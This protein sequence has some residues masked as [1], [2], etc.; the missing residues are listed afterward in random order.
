MKL[1]I[2]KVLKPQGIK[3]ELKVQPLSSPEFF[4]E[5]PQVFIAGK[6]A[7]IEYV[8][9]RN[10]G[11]YLKLDLIND[12]N[13]AEEYRD[14]IIYA[15]R[16]ALPELKKN[17]Y[18]YDDLIGCDVVFEDGEGVGELVD[19]QNYGTADIFEI[20]RG[21]TAILVPFVEGVFENID[22]VNKKIVANRKR[23]L[24]VTDYED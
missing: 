14:K 12:R 6:T 4:K 7:R 13:E 19:I 16:D 23:Y 3:G 17:Q 21:Y 18:F 20:K 8:H 11:V 15:E 24:E 5:I 2:G 9:I 10:D 1:Q 22:T